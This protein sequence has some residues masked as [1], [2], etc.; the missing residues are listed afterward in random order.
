MTEEA[1]GMKHNAKPQAIKGSAG[2]TLIEMMITVV[3][4]GILA[5]IGLANYT[6]AEEK[7]ID[8]TM[9]ADLHGAMVFIE[10]Y[11]IENETLPPNLAA[12]EAES[13]YKLS[14]GVQWDRFE[15]GVLNGVDSVGLE[16]SHPQSPNGWRA[17]YPATG[18]KIELR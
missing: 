5:T 17:H 12:F 13:G 16:V 4:V 6:S 14:P 3:V 8:A 10:D 11:R 7:S 9:K 2:F 18:A 15:P 1:S